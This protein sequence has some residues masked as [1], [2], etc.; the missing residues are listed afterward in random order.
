MDV[1][2]ALVD[3]S[4]LRRVEPYL[5]HVRYR[6]LESVRQYAADKLGEETAPTAL[7]HGSY[8]ASFGTEAYL[9]SLDI[10]SG[11]KRRKAL[12]LELENLLAGVDAGLAAG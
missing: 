4:L 12:E 3:H 8:F 7:R 1:V 5:G 6:M 10:H 9:E 2:E 11:V